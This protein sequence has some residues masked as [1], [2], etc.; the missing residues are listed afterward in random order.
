VFASNQTAR[1]DR[2]TT[3]SDTSERIHNRFNELLDARPQ[4]R[5][6]VTERVSYLFP[7]PETTE[8]DVS[9]LTYDRR[10]RAEPRAE[11]RVS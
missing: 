8:W 6:K 2:Q 3:A 11:L 4:E 9:E 5:R 7:R 10:R 1:E